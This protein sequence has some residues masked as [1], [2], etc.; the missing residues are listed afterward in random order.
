MTLCPLCELRAL[1]WR[2]RRE[3]RGT[4]DE[5]TVMRSRGGASLYRHPAGLNLTYLTSARKSKFCVGS[6][7][8]VPKA[9]ECD[10]CG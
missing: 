1:E 9:C 7:K 2:A 4:N 8:R 6:W 3:T 10:S 5:V